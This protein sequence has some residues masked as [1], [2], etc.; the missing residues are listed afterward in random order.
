MYNSIL[1]MIIGNDYLYIIKFIKRIKVLLKYC[2]FL[3]FLMFI[4]IKLLIFMEL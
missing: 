1:Y 2:I 4:W 3:R